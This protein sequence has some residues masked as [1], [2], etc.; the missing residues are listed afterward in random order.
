M[1]V[2]ELTVDPHTRLPLLVL[3]D[4]TGDQSLPLWIGA[5]EAHAIQTELSSIELDRPVA[6]DLLKQILVG[7]GARVSHVEVDDVRDHVY[8]ATI[9][10]QRGGK[11]PARE[12]ILKVD[13]RPSDAIALALRCR[14]PIRVRASVLQRA[15]GEAPP[16]N[17]S[18]G[19]DTAALLAALPD[20]EFGKWK[21]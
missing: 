17:R 13:S 6:H 21:M 7:V 18:Q 15:R 12:R 10:L 11:A 5:P 9:Y 19:P 16:A 8:Y 4:E 1:R 14:A 2:R 20:A 3:T